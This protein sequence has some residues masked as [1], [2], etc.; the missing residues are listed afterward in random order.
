VSREASDPRSSAADGATEPDAKAN[1][2]VSPDAGDD[3]AAN[4]DDDNTDDDMDKQFDLPLDALLNEALMN[5]G[6]D[7]REAE[8]ALEAQTEEAL[9]AA[10]R[11]EYL[12]ALRRLQAD[13]DNFRK[14]SMRQQTELLE[15]AT[16]G[17]CVRL[18]PVL[19]ALDLATAHVRG[20]E[21]S[22][23]AAKALEQ[24]DSLLRDIL[25]REGIQ[26]IDAVGVPFDPT[27]HDAVG[28]IAPTPPPRPAAKKRASA[29]KPVAAPGAQGPGGPTE[30]DEK[31]AALARAEAEAKAE[32]DA[33]AEAEAKAA[34]AAAE[35]SGVPT[36]AQV[37]RA[38]YRL[39]SKVLRPAMV[40]VGG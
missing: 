27:I 2:S 6:T 11:D 37:M 14:R 25:A 15:R 36:V 16:E 13:F 7:P 35:S 33:R 3:A 19:D 38:G 28:R 22:N 39:K 1:G 5:W 26:R 34:A 31:A 21:G 30:A 23:D 18:L 9:V 32:A 20:Q 17:L 12:D 40:I 8:K 24:I 4:T 29:S 10:E